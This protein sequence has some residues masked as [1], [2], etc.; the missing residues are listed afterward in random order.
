MC[1]KSGVVHFLEFFII[2]FSACYCMEVVVERKQPMLVISDNEEL[3]Q[4]LIG[5]LNKYELLD[6]FQSYLKPDKKESANNLILIYDS[7]L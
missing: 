3:H 6:S 1:N 7:N 2:L 4:K 5:P